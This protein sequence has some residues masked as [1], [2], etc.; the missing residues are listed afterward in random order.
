MTA[1]LRNTV[2][3]KSDGQR[4]LDLGLWFNA[5]GCGKGEEGNRRERDTKLGKWK[6]SKAK[7]RKGMFKKSVFPP[8]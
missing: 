1:G 5:R 4:G 7:Y 2:E 6:M 3:R 8:R